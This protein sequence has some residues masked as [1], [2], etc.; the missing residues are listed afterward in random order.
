[1]TNYCKAVHNTA[2]AKRL[3]FLAELL[4][5]ESLTSFI[6]FAKGQINE[7]YNLIDPQGSDKGEFISEWKLRLN[8]S[9]EE[10]LDIVNKQY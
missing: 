6:A 4:R 1:M 7:K 9:R 3:G 5:K 10:L 8:I 2:V